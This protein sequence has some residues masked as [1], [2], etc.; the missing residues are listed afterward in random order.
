MV[1]PRLTR[2]PRPFP[3]SQAMLNFEWDKYGLL[4]RAQGGDVAASAGKENLPAAKLRQHI[5]KFV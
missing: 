1:G 5:L 4:M 2:P 3:Y